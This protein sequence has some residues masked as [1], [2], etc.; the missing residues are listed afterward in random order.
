MPACPP[1][2][3]QWLCLAAVATAEI[4]EVFMKNQNYTR[5]L[6]IVVAICLLLTGTALASVIGQLIDGY[7]VYLGAGAELSLLNDK[8]IGIATLSFRNPV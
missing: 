5:K 4:Q 2:P 7:D 1:L 6:A 3:Q 8:K